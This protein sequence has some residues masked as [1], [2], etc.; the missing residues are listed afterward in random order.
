M[1][2][3]QKQNA[4]SASDCDHNSNLSIPAMCKIFMDIATDHSKIMG[5]S[6]FDLEPKNLFWVVTKTKI[7]IM[8]KPKMLQDILV[9]T[10]PNKPNRIKCNRCYQISQNNTPI[11]QAKSEWII[12]DLNADRIAKPDEVYPQDF[13]HLDCDVLP[14]GFLRLD[15]D[16]KDENIAYSYTVTSSDIDA[17]NH[18]NNAVYPRLILNAFSCSELN[19]L[20][21]K[22]FEIHYK[23]QCHEGEVL[24]VK[25]KT[26]GE[27]IFVVILKQNS[28]VAIICKI[29]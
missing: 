20:N 25:K 17:G 19:N 4:V 13:E 11:I 7:K 9:K 16:L 22:E 2:Y 8:Q 24:N 3:L 12:M 10:W 14:E 26:V 1:K 18:V 23:K 5:V 21:I 15:Q 6:I 29:N 27:E 28:E